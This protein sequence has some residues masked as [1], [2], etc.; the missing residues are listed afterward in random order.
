MAVLLAHIAI[1]PLLP[2]RALDVSASVVT[3]HYTPQTSYV[4]ALVSL[5]LQQ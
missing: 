4:V 2:P 3:D 5:L 1:F